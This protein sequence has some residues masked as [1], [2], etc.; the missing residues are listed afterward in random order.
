MPGEE[1]ALA[2]K[3]VSVEGPLA[4]RIDKARLA[5]VGKTVRWERAR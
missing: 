3:R 5:W 4:G 2:F 1:V